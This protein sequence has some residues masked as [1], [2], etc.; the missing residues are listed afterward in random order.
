MDIKKVE[1]PEPTEAQE[2]VDV[3]IVTLKDSTVLTVPNDPENRYYN[4]V[5]EWL[6]NHKT[7]SSK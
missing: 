3:Y 1:V 7:K 4:E 5:Q 2:T 6:K